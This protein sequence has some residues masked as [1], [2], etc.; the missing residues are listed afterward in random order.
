[1]TSRNSTI[2]SRGK[3]GFL[4]AISFRFG[5]HLANFL[6]G[7]VLART[8]GPE[9]FGTLAIV[10]AYIAIV[11]SLADAGLA[12]GLTQRRHVRP[13][14]LDSV[15]LW[16]MTTSLV[17]TAIAAG[18]APLVARFYEL[19]GLEPLIAASSLLILGNGLAAV[20][21]VVLRRRLGFK[22]IALM[23][24]AATL[25][26]GGAGVAMALSGYGIWSL[27]V[28][29]LVISG[30]TLVLAHAW[31]QWRPRWRF[32]PKAIR[33]LA[34]FS[35]AMY[36]ARLLDVVLSRLDVVLF[37]K[38][39]DMEVM[40]HYQRAKSVSTLVFSYM[41]QSATEVLFP[42]LS[43]IGRNT[44]RVLNLVRLSLDVVCFGT[45]FLVGAMYLAAEAIVGIVYGDAWIPAAGYLRPIA[46]AAFAM[47]ISAVLTTA[48]SARG[49]SAQFLRAE[50]AKKAA[51]A[52]HLVVG[53][54][55]GLEVFVA[56]LA[57]RAVV[58]V[59]VNL[60]FTSHELR[61]RAWTLGRPIAVQMAIGAVALAAALALGR[62]GG[63]VL[64]LLCAHALAYFGL[65]AGLRTT[66][67]TT[68]AR[69]LGERAGK[70]MDFLQR[71][72]A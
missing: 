37:A 14:H 25:A 32:A 72:R 28:Q 44:P 64:L 18:S 33:Q 2:V 67:F 29:Q 39:V 1:M 59:L 46:L 51:L 55:F 19:P 22:H 21:L 30:T 3:E 12:S 47:P 15:F 17:L 57:V 54:L 66:A 5:T 27:V 40:G 8:L 45:F 4:W 63:G 69:I 71:H 42:L 11:N 35:S 50:I 10:L 43:A 36:F 56:T 48:L 9:L 26:G 7:V 60:L 70:A 13:A 34:G 53:Y 65:S 61:V 68:T 58:A 41:F 23:R 62:A 16:C 24:F 52:G 31:S 6:L 49:N 20:P 38:L